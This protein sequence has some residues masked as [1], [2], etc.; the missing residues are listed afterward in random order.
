MVIFNYNC[1]MA[2]RTHE[3]FSPIF[4]MFMQLWSLCVLKHITLEIIKGI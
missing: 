2:L 4:M 1:D 3:G